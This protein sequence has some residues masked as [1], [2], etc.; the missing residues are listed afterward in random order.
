MD[1]MV[2]DI[3]GSFDIQDLGEL[4]HLLCIR[5][6]RNQDLGTI[7]IS[8][9]S[10]INTIAKRFNIMPGRSITSLMEP[11]MNLQIATNL[12]NNLNIPYA[13]LIGSIN[14]CTIS[15]QPDI[16]YATNKCMQFTSWPNLS[17][18]EAMKRIVWYL[19]HTREFGI[20]YKQ[21]GNGI[22]GYAHNLA[23]YTDADFTGDINNRKS[24]MGWV[25]TFNGS[26]ISW[27]S[28]NQ[29]LV[30]RSS[31][32]SELIAGSFASAEGIWLIWLGKDFKHIFTPIPLF[33]DNQSFMIFSK[34]NV[35]NN[36][37]KHIDTHFHYTWD[38][39]M[40]GNIRLHYIL[41]I[42]NPADI[43]MKPLLPCKH[44]HLLNQLSICH[45]WGGV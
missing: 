34:N 19:L 10:F 23:R 11:S 37:T 33:T 43:L 7:H 13:S 24:K 9:L 14:Y 15:T 20:L 29:G 17:H 5:I 3:W 38:Q 12:D 22:E 6:S 26:P 36:Q 41:S 4:D 40:T 28:K 25:F 45:V 16:S 31:M 42:N 30:T 44:A 2:N 27:A 1:R 32:E 35:N 21:D 18:W 39:V 8:Q